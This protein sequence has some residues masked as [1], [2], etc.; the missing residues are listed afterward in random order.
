MRIGHPKALYPVFFRPMIHYALDAAM[1]VEHRSLSLVVGVGEREFGE[2]CRGYDGLRVIPQQSPTGTGDALGAAVAGLAEEGDVLV[3]YGDAVLLRASTLNEML[4]LHAETGAA[5]TVGLGSGSGADA[6]AYCFRVKDLVVALKNAAGRGDELD[7]ADVV[8]ALSAAHA[9][10]AEYRIVDPLETMD[11]NDFYGLW[12]VEAELQGRFNR[13][14]MLQGVALQ[15]PRTT[16]IDPRCR[17]EREVRIE[18]GCTVINSVLG[19]G[20]RVEN[21]CRIIDSEIGPDSLL[22]QGTCLEKARLGRGCRV[23]PYFIA[24]SSGGGPL[25]RRTI[26]ENDVFI[27]ASSQAIAPVTLG[28]RTFVATG[29]SVTE[30]APADSFVISRNRQVTRPGLSKKHGGSKGP[31]ALP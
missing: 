6:A 13:D 1:A 10:T 21:F 9:A 3:L 5:C 2:Q 26:I 4:R 31:G 12:R 20:V 24:S 18:G 14:L 23:G 28:A 22:R 8:L 29:T 27:G 25:N 17:I 19:A 15:D 16:L 30:D 11:V 7:L